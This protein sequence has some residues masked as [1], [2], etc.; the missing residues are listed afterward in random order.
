M[1]EERALDLVRVHHSGSP[2]TGSGAAL[3]KD[4]SLAHNPWCHATLYLGRRCRT[5]LRGRAYNNSGIQQ[6]YDPTVRSGLGAALNEGFIGPHLIN[7]DVSRFFEMISKDS[8][9]G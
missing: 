8:S 5:P 3:E 1:L 7:I 9:E 4:L 6:G 2:W